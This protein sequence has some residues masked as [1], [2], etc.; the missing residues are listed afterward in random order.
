MENTSPTESVLSDAVSSLGKELA[1]LK[2]WSS[3]IDDPVKMAC[4]VTKV[5]AQYVA[6]SEAVKEMEVA[7]AAGLATWT[8]LVE[9]REELDA[10]GIK[11]SSLVATLPLPGEL[12]EHAMSLQEAV[13]SVVEVGAA[14]K[15][16]LTEH[17]RAVRAFDAAAERWAAFANLND[18]APVRELRAITGSFRIE[19]PMEPEI[20][21][22]LPAVENRRNRYG[23][24]VSA[25]E[26][27]RNS[28]TGW[29]PALNTW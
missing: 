18:S 6:Y 4:L 7:Y 9:R 16:A 12:R 22:L 3:L 1:Q 26:Y 25:V 19:E 10:Q 23:D 28:I 2:G 8:K 27:L 14:E 17:K 29:G 15:E 24:P 21:K 13:G 5:V 20:F 11:L